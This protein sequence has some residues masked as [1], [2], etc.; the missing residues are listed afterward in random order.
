MGKVNIQFLK[1]IDWQQEPLCPVLNECD[2]HVYRIQISANLQL[3]DLFSTVLTQA[4]KDRGG[5]YFQQ[6]DRQ[7]FVI[8]RGAQRYILSR[9]LS[10]PAHQ[11]IFALGANKKP[12]LFTNKSAGL[13]YNISH[14]GDWIILVVAKST[15]GADVEYKDPGFN[16]QDIL[17]DNFSADENSFIDEK[18]SRERFYLLWTRKEA[19]LKATGKGL[20]DHLNLTPSLDGS[21][22]MPSILQDVRRDWQ[23]ISFEAAN[24]YFGSICVEKK[25]A[26]FRFFDTAFQQHEKLPIIV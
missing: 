17:T 12:Y 15:V 8:S 4:E 25:V 1:H 5:S 26:I 7:R 9:Y 2:V 16:F 20:G 21:H 19:L 13:H 22:N 14:A 6:K 10:I 11:L 3:L 23:T 24:D 18:D